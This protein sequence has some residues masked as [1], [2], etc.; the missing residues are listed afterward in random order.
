MIKQNKAPPE[1]QSSILGNEAMVAMNEALVLGSLRQHELTAAAEALNGRLEVEIADRTR[2]E[3]D[4]RVS[5]V[6]YRRL[7]EMASDGV[8]LVDPVSGRI[9]DTNPHMT[10]LSGRPQD[11]LVGKPLWKTGWFGNRAASRLLL[12]N[13]NTTPEIRFEQLELDHPD[14][15]LQM[16][17]VVAN[18][19]RQNGHSVIQ[20]NIRDITERKLA[21]EILLRNEGLFTAIIE[22][23][24]MGVFV[25]DAELRLQQVNPNA[26]PIFK[27]IHPLIGHD[28][29]KVM[30]TLWGSPTAD[31]VIS[32]FRHTLET[33]ETYRSPEFNHRRKDTG[34]QEAY[35]WE[36]QCVTL[37][38]GGNGVVCYYNN[39]TER[40][41]AEAARR[42]LAVLTAS[43][44]KLKKEVVRRKTVEESLQKN[45]QLQILLLEQSRQQEEQ[46]RDLS[47]RI[48]NIQEDERKRISRELHDVISQNLIGI[49]GSIAALA[50]GDP[51]G[52]PAS[53]QRKIAKTQR[54]VEDSVQR[55]HHFA[56]ELRPAVLDDLGLIPA[57][58]AYLHGFMIETGIRTALSAFAGIEQADGDMRT[59]LYRI[60]QEALTN[61]A[62]HAKANEVA[63]S[64]TA[65][66][67]VVLMEIRDDGIGFKMAGKAH[68][69]K[70]NRLGLLGMKERIEMV[71]GCFQIESLPGEG[72]TVRVEFTH[73]SPSES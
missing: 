8:L 44:V 51:A 48:L 43:N 35:E 71:G 55:V 6:R 50:K 59:A 26:M 29:A 21:E 57:L 47:H 46:L 33:R 61:V 30:Q 10:Q 7:F 52:D 20:F 45:Q 70:T 54:I 23:A 28:F 36:I 63:V 13:L 49:N 22:L 31:D 12:A 37:P 4:L 69:V 64:I 41:N 1:G 16:V 65:L 62:R 17:E 25:V 38:A 9:T 72:T 34:D 18:L 24:P 60:A 32:C 42:T 66:N 11:Q 15:S 5:E 73:L 39:I 2:A 68:A 3:D 56:R 67:G 14:G 27:D 58:H 40:E 53:F 19:Y